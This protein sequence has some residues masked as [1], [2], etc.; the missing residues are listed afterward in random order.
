MVMKLGLRS[1]EISFSSR[2]RRSV[3]VNFD[4]C[5]L[6]KQLISPENYQGDV[7]INN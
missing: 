6:Y 3:D 7:M 5:E 1:F 2:L 4:A